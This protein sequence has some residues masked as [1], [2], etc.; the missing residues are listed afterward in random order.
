MVFIRKYYTECSLT[1]HSCWEFCVLELHANCKDEPS[2]QPLFS[3]VRYIRHLSHQTPL[4][5]PTTCI[6]APVISTNFF[7][8]FVTNVYTQCLIFH[9]Q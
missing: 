6:P 2:A 5:V 9:R 7:F 4:I 1:F 3:I 8:L